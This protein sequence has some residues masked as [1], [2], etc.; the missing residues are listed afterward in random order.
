[1]INRTI[2]KYL[3][4]INQFAEPEQKDPKRRIKKNI[5]LNDSQ[6]VNEY[7][8]LP[9]LSDTLAEEKQYKF[10]ICS[11]IYKIQ[12]MNVYPLPRLLY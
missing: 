3:S 5:K 9:V 4:L 11:L 2:N 10:K 6:S 12:I 7:D 1:M 8:N